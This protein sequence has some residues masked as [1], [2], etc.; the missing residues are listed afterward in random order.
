MKNGDYDRTARLLHV[1][2]ILNQN[3][4]GITLEKIAGKTGVS[5]RTTRRDLRDLEDWEH[6]NVP[7]IWDR[8]KVRIEPGVVLP[9]VFFRLQEAM[10]IFLASRLLLAYTNAY[11]PSIENAF[12]KLSSVVPGPLR[13]QICRTMEWM[14]K[15]K[16]DERFLQTLGTLAQAWTHG[17]TVKIRYWT[18]GEERAT[19]RI[20]EPY[21]IQPAALEHA[22]YVIAY[23]HQAGEVRTFKIERIENIELLD[24][25]YTVPEDFDANEYLGSAWGIVVDSQVKT[26]KL[27]FG[28]GIARIARETTWHPS[29][30]TEWQLDGSAIVT[31]NVSVTVELVTFILGWGEKVEVLE[32]EEL[33][34]EV[35]ETAK[36]MLDVY[37]KK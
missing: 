29:Q 32:P 35:M 20:I 36:A 9:P 3:P 19:E 37:R 6:L 13:D 1:L 28:P 7:V 4:N 10:T 12:T 2:H 34:E 16:P 18:L 5:T 21:F 15:R 33:R 23:C 8:G 14:Q 26:V 11:N 22:N 31:M 30:T 17:R 25:R 24:E 27:R